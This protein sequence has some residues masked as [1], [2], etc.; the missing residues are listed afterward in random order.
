MYLSADTLMYITLLNY[1]NNSG[2]PGN[3]CEDTSIN[4]INVY[5]RKI[6]IDV[7]GPCNPE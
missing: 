2:R 7:L 1:I 6:Q 5:I 4:T 3:Y